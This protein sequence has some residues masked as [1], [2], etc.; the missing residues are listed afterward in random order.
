MNPH[1]LCIY[2]I[3]G[4]VVNPVGL[5]GGMPNGA[6]TS[7]IRHTSAIHRPYVVRRRILGRED[8]SSVM[9]THA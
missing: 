9:H 5:G 1:L 3:T 8:D 4:I 7:L 2:N 6:F